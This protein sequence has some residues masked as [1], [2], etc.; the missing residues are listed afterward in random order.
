MNGKFNVIGILDNWK[1]GDLPGNQMVNIILNDYATIHN[2]N[3]SLTAELASDDEIDY[4][5][6][7]LIKDLEQVRKKAKNNIAKIN[8][9]IRNS[10][11]EK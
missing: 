9:M 2:G 1:K 5:V 11:A 8:E 6:D 3:I 7:K 4:A 10:L